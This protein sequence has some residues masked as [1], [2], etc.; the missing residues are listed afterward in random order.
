MYNFFLKESVIISSL[1]ILAFVA[2][3]LFEC[4]YSDAFGYDYVFIEI[5]LKKMVISILCIAICFFPLLI[6]FWIFFFLG[7]RK[8]KE[9]RLIALQMVLPIPVLIFLY[10]SGFDSKI[11]NWLLALSI[12]LAAI[13]FIRVLFKARKLGWHEA[14]SQIAT[15]EGIKEFEGPRPKGREPR[16]IDKVIG[17]CVVLLFFVALGLM[18]RG[19]GSAVAHWKNTYQTFTL[20]GEEVAIIAAYGERLIVGGVVGDQFNYKLSVVPKDSEKLIGL[21]IA[22][23]PE[24]LSEPFYFR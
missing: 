2:A 4:G 8:E 14:M 17:F 5:D 15:A 1:S 7:L 10:I 13:T 6:Y 24:F 19:I 21:K 23:L 20:D 9:S 11:M 3:F 12:L 16:V 18:V 22:Y